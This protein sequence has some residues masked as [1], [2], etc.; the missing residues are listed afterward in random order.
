[1]MLRFAFVFV[2]LAVGLGAGR[3]EAPVLSVFELRNATQATLEIVAERMDETG[4]EPVQP[5]RLAPGQ[6]RFLQLPVG[7]WRLTATAIAVQGV[8][9]LVKEFYLP[10]AGP[11]GIVFDPQSFGVTKLEDGPLQI[12]GD[13][14]DTAPIAGMPPVAPDW[15]EAEYPPRRSFCTELAVPAVNPYIAF[16]P[17]DESCSP[18]WSRSGF[19]GDR[20][21]CRLCPEGSSYERTN[22]CC[23]VD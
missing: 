20:R 1:M 3:A 10:D 5:V 11:Y 7:R 23:M 22:A 9:P 17:A 19:E 21:A 2:L 12:P 8:D 4:G 14:N 13:E 15:V 16:I 6:R 18:P